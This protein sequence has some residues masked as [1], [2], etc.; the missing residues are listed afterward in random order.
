M[1]PWT[2]GAAPISGAGALAWGPST[3]NGPLEALGHFSCISVLHLIDTDWPRVLEIKVL[4]HEIN[5]LK[6]NCTK[7]SL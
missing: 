5:L 6:Y 4:Q 1:V 7:Y 2:V 3:G